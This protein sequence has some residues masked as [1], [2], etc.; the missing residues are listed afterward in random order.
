MHRHCNSVVIADMSTWT[1]LTGPPSQ[2]AM[3]TPQSSSARGAPAQ[4][5]AGLQQTCLSRFYARCRS[6]SETPTYADAAST[7]ACLPVLLP[8]HTILAWN[9]VSDE[10]HFSCSI[11]DLMA[12]ITSPAGSYSE[13]VSRHHPTREQWSYFRYIS[14]IPRAR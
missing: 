12:A 5:D 11:P 8:R 13:R 4:D 6:Q 2:A 1:F 9:V 3:C 14:S 7:S 10:P